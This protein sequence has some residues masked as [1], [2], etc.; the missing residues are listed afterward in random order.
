MQGGTGATATS[1]ASTA[2]P[3]SSLPPPLSVPQ[4]PMPVHL[5]STNANLETSV[6]DTAIGFEFKGCRAAYGHGVRRRS[7]STVL[8]AAHLQVVVCAGARTLKTPFA[9][10]EVGCSGERKTAALVG[11]VVS[12]RVLN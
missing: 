12:S 9:A 2:G 1:N 8:C 5:P 3:P 11:L 6:L 7:A 10:R 4:S